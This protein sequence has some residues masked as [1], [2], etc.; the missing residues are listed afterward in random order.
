[1]S[2]ACECEQCGQRFQ[3]ADDL[4]GKRGRCKQCG[5]IFRIAAATGPTAAE[6]YAFDAIDQL[7]NPPAAEPPSNTRGKK[8]KAKASGLFGLSALP[9]WGFN[10]Y[11]GAIVTVLAVAL[12]VGGVPKFALA[13]A[14]M[15]LC[16]WPF[17]AAGFSYRFGT[18][19]R[20]GPIA[21]LLY[22]FFMPYRIHYRLTHRELFQKLRAPT[23]TLRDYSLLLLGLC[24]LPVVINAAQ[25]MDKLKR[26]RPPEID[27]TQFVAR[28]GNRIGPPVAAPEHLARPP[29]L[30]LAKAPAARNFPV[31]PVPADAAV[32]EPDVPGPAAAEPA[33]TEVPS[34]RQADSD[35]R[36]LER[37]SRRPEIGRP[38]QVERGA[39]RPFP[40]RSALQGASPDFP[41]ESTVTITIHGVANPEM[42]ERLN[43]AIIAIVKPLG[44]EWRVN[45]STVG[46]DTIFRVCPVT[47]TKAF[48]DKIDFG[49]VKSVD[50]QSIDVDVG[51]PGTS[52]QIESLEHVDSHACS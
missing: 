36:T 45:F 35:N 47:D 3:V 38:P 18:A 43:K 34:S 8:K 12:V 31:R 44:G 11:R 40:P 1:M 17:V 9:L 14:G 50:G 46:G 49:K 39:R 7:S 22:I 52:S 21:G 13:M 10:V 29:R 15:F 25:E 42:R 41:P 6:I 27:W 23:L 2:I 37:R 30:G 26:N 51:V 20:D 19:F 48:A 24:F 5:H 4:A 32:A 28:P 16:V 33:A